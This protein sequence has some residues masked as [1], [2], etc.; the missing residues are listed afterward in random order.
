MALKPPASAIAS[1]VRSIRGQVTISNKVLAK[2]SKA[3]VLRECGDQ[4]TLYLTLED[5]PGAIARLDQA[6][7]AVG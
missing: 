5:A 2:T 1:A 4:I 6:E 7:M 3:R